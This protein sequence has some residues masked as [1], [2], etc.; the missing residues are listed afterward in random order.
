MPALRRRVINDALNP[1]H[2][3]WHA[4]TRYIWGEPCY[5]GFCHRQTLYRLKYQLFYTR[6]LIHT[7]SAG[8]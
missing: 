8:F 4:A 5:A 7:C 1:G 2:F 3:A 6:N